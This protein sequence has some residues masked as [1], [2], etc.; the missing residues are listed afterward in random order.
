M[1]SLLR[2]DPMPKRLVL[3]SMRGWH[4]TMARNL[5]IF[6]HCWCQSLSALKLNHLFTLLVPALVSLL[7]PKLV[8]V[9]VAVSFPNEPNFVQTFV[10][11]F[12][13]I[14]SKVVIDMTVPL[15]ASPH[16]KKRLALL[17]TL[18]HHALAMF[19]SKLNQ[20]FMLLAP[21]LVVWFEGVVGISFPSKPDFVKNSLSIKS[22]SVVDMTVPCVLTHCPRDCAV[23]HQEDSSWQLVCRHA[24]KEPR[25]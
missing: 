21:E 19:L 2:F 9:G 17:A 22:H 25:E 3:L 10:Q 18:W 24:A 13:S 15:R 7:V 16:P 1:I 23:G 6:S 14:K 8:G 4:H 12:L 11:T 20:L 5:T